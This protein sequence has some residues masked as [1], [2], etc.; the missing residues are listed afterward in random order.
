M[1][2]LGYGKKYNFNCRLNIE[3]CVKTLTNSVEK[4]SSFNDVVVKIDGHKFQLFRKTDYSN[5]SYNPVFY[6]TLVNIGEVSRIEGYFSLSIISL[7][8]TIF[9]YFWIIVLPLIAM[10]SENIWG[11]ILVTLLTFSICSLITMGNLLWGKSKM[12]PI[13]DFIQHEL[14][15]TPITPQQ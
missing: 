3:E 4:K 5:S 15:A 10:N 8:I 6:G 11:K 2:L 9:L 1:N 12:K 13:L 14:Q 7:V